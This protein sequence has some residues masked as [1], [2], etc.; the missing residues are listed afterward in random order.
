MVSGAGEF[1]KVRVL[2][3]SV[4]T[5]CG[6]NP[7]LLKNESLGGTGILSRMRTRMVGGFLKHR[8]VE[9]LCA[10][11]VPEGFLPDSRQ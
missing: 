7:T 2:L 4:R 11:Q 9:R 5:R 6:R 1:R 3:F 8:M 10:K